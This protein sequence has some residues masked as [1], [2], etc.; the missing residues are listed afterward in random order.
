MTNESLTAFRY[1]L[2]AISLAAVSCTATGYTRLADGISLDD[3]YVDCCRDGES[4]KINWSRGE[5][6]GECADMHQRADMFDEAADYYMK[7]FNLHSGRYL[8]V[9]DMYKK[10]LAAGK[11]E[12]HEK[13]TEH[14]LS[15]CLIGRLE[16]HEGTD[17]IGEFCSKLALAYESYS[18]G[19][20]A[21]QAHR[22]A[23][24]DYGIVDDCRTIGRYRGMRL[25][26]KLADDLEEK[27]ER[28]LEYRQQT[29]RERAREDRENRVERE[30][31]DR[32][33]EANYRKAMSEAMEQ[34]SYNLG[35]GNLTQI[36]LQSNLRAMN[37]VIPQSPSRSFAAAPPIRSPDPEPEERRR[38]D[39]IESRY[40][41]SPS[42]PLK[43]PNFR[44]RSWAA[45]DSTGT[46]ADKP[47]QGNGYVFDTEKAK[48]SVAKGL[49]PFATEGPGMADKKE[50]FIYR[51]GG[52]YD[53][54]VEFFYDE[55]I[56][57]RYAIRNRCSVPLVAVSSEGGADYIEVGRR[58]SLGE[59]RS[60][61]TAHNGRTFAFC[62]KGTHP[63]GENGKYW[64]SGPYR[65]RSVAP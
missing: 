52:E 30:R 10:L 35:P 5:S 48:R 6:C 31:A 57:G 36:A 38:V 27:A 21:E 54:C 37:A 56:N 64:V 39:P 45:D 46:D 22:R 25:T 1:F 28:R 65:C 59:K 12:L 29:I 60:E 4:C 8:G 20:Y 32:E 19:E 42:P 40:D 50:P 63:I 24:D 15:V 44:I 53:H 11:I 61:A 33:A 13:L 49:S 14:L 47:G 2:M 17:V 58:W 9:V 41:A 55:E 7:Q 51:P 3:D 43:A 23:C 16:S 26:A 62:R 34:A 18:L